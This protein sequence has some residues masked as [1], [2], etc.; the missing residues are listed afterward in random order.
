M[1]SINDSTRENLDPS[2]PPRF[3][4][5]PITTALQLGPLAFLAGS[6][7][8]P[9]FNAIWRPHNQKSDPVGNAT[10]RFLELNLTD[11]SFHFQVIPGVV[12][13]RG[14]D[15]QKD[16]GLYGL[17]YLQRVSDADPAPS[18]SVHPH[19]YS[20]TAGQ[21]L[22]IEPGLFMLVPAS[23][24]TNTGDPPVPIVNKKSIVRMGSIP[25]GTTV[26]MQGPSPDSK[27]KD[28]KPDIPK[29]MPFTGSPGVT[30]AS[31]PPY[32]A[33]P[34]VP[35]GPNPPAM[36]IQP[37]TVD[38]AA[39]SCRRSISRWTRW[40]RPLSAAGHSQNTSS[41]SSM[42]PTRCSG[43]RSRI[44]ISLG[45]SRSISLQIPCRRMASLPKALAA[46]TRQ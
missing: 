29:L 4:Q 3:Q 24:Q 45:I 34:P 17:H 42:I 13:N 31:F 32:T 37:V 44:R 26:L 23:K 38:G 25:H 27:P 7:R 16:L 46:C 20:Q 14:L 10:K 39:H 21:A 8:G 11:D 41:T 28:G 33:P 1:P 43:M 2:V 12:P 22:H 9:G 35:P 36:G 19:G 18:P 40:C 30:A 6:W 5:G 15:P